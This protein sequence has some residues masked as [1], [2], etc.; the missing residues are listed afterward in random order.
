MELCERVATEQD[1]A[2]LAELTAA[3]IAA[4][5]AKKKRLK[6]LHSSGERLPDPPK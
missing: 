6:D 4:L 2:Q 3:I 5:D 1:P